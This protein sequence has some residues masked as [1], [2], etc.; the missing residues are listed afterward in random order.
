MAAVLYAIRLSH[1][2]EAARLMLE[3]K[4]TD[5]RVKYIRAGLHPL[6]LRAAGFERGTTPALKLDGKRFQ[7]SREIAGALDEIEARPPLFP[8]D[9]EARARVKRAEEWG[10]REFQPVPRRFLRWGSRNLQ[11]VRRWMGTE[12]D[13]TPLAGVAARLAMPATIPFARISGATDDAVRRDLEELP[14]LL[15]EVDELIASGAIGGLEPNAADYQ[16]GTTARVLLAFDDLRPVVERTAAGELGMRIWPDFRYR[17][18][19]YLPP[20]WLEQV[21]VGYRMT[22]EP[23]D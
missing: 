16:I 1:P 23:R 10:E 2:A 14:N 20:S 15:K 7:G 9:G 5:H 18:P 11:S 17:V 12:V 21:R 22:F 8:A 19:P 4:G 3:R 6:V 13:P